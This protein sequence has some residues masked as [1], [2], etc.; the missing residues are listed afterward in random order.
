[1]PASTS[2]SHSLTCSPAH[3]F[4][5]HTRHVDDWWEPSYAPEGLVGVE[6]AP[7]AGGHVTH[8]LADER[9]GPSAH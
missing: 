3:A 8:H 9:R 5:T 1:M 4:D 2:S 6:I 7:R